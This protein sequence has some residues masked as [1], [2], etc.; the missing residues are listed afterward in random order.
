MN[1]RK[2]PCAQGWTLIM[3]ALG[4]AAC[5]SHSTATDRG[6]SAT[7]GSDSGRSP[8]GSDDGGS[9]GDSPRG[10]S[11][12][13]SASSDAFSRDGSDGSDGPDGSDGSVSSGDGAGSAVDGAI[14]TDFVCNL[15]IGESPTGQWFDSGFLQAVDATRWESI[16]IAHHY[17]NLWADPTD[18]GWTT[19]FDPY[20]GPAHVCAENSETPDRVIFVAAQWSETTAAEWETDLTAIVSNIETKYIG[21]K[22]IELMALTGAPATM[23]C[24]FTGSGTNETIIPEVGYEAI[25]AMPAMFP[26]L[27][28][29]LPHFDVPQCSD[30]VLSEGQTM[31]QYTTA[32]AMDVAA[33]VFG[34]YYLAHP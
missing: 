18:P 14:P 3:L 32:G 13:A 29:A 10:P 25:D 24:P 5:G 34:P 1:I 9:S 16:W 11:D 12:G 26:G 30:F 27:V 21:V 2:R 23:P 19:A 7:A 33:N 22:R 28:F 31:P 4:A 8:D 6:A 17:T 20:P 15:V